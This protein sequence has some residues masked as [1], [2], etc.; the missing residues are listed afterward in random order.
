MERKEEQPSTFFLRS[1]LDSF[2]NQIIVYRQAIE[3]FTRNSGCTLAEKELLR[4]L[5]DNEVMLALPSGV[6]LAAAG[7]G[8]IKASK[9]AK[10]KSAAKKK[11]NKL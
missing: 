4:A 2:N 10:Q 1:F 7:L 11:E 6:K 9:K 3:L 5:G 8:A